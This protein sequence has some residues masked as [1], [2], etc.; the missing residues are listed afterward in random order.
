M[1]IASIRPPPPV[2]TV[3]KGRLPSAELPSRADQKFI[4]GAVPR[5]LD[6]VVWIED[7]PHCAGELPSRKVS[8]G[9]GRDR[10]RTEKNQSWN[11]SP[12]EISEPE[13]N[14]NRYL[15]IV[16][17]ETVKI[18][19]V[20]VPVFLESG[21]VRDGPFAFFGSVFETRR[22]GPG[23]RSKPSPGRLKHCARQIT[24]H[25]HFGRGGL[26]PWGRT[27]TLITRF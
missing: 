13:P 15:N 21:P 24:G 2:W 22:N 18:V 23:V 19:T 16:K 1:K 5:H 17:T 27:E 26:L 14:P 11:R 10:Y 9:T 25:S 6:P 7:R 8:N 20:L 12:S 4:L 3:Q